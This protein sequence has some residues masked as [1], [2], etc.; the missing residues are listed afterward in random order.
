MLSFVKK[1]MELKMFQKHHNNV[2][3]MLIKVVLQTNK[4]E[5]VLEARP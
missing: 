1:K 5:D 4:I 3:E 2:N